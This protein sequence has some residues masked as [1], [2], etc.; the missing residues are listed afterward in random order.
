METIAPE[1]AKKLLNRDFANLAQRVQR[2]GKLNRAERAMLQGMASGAGS[3]ATVAEN[4]VELARILGVTRRSLQNWRKRK[5]APKAVANG[6]HEV[7]AWRDEFMQRHGLEGD[8]VGTDAE[9]A[10]RARKLLAEVE[11]RELRLAVKRG[12]FFADYPSFGPSAQAD[13]AAPGLSAQSTI[14]PAPSANASLEPGSSGGLA[15]SSLR[16]RLDHVHGWVRRY[17]ALIPVSGISVESVRFESRQTKSS[18]RLSNDEVRKRLVRVWGPRC[19]YCDRTDVPLQ[20]EHIVAR[21]RGGISRMHNLGL[22]CR[23][24]NRSKGSRLLEDYLADDPERLSAILLHVTQ[25]RCCAAAVNSSIDALVAGLGSMQLPLEL[26]SGIVTRQ[27]RERLGLSKSHCIDAACVGDVKQVLNWRCPVFLIK[28][29]GRGSYQRTRTDRNGSPQAY[30][31]RQKR[32]Y[33]F[34]TGDV[35]RA[36]VRRRGKSPSVRTGRLTVRSC[37]WFGLRSHGRIYQAHWKKCCRIARG[38]GYAY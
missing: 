19:I 28:A 38:D 15:A 1:I 30:L 24:C 33:G 36:T 16:S 3:T 6:F 21:S 23:R 11:E 35:V 4:Y 31:P 25:N 26:A 22:A 18:A 20:A 37:G 17:R 34:Q 10:L 8:P 5:D 13:A 32:F 14:A 2:G 27:N 29:T 7:A 12:E 9:S